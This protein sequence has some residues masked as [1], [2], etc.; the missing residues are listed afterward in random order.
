MAP[1]PLPATALRAIGR[2]PPV[3]PAGVQWSDR[4]FV[5]A[6]QYPVRYRE[7]AQT[8]R[9]LRRPVRI[10]PAIELDVDATLQLRSRR[11]IVSAPVLVP[12]RR[13]I[14]RLLLLVD[15]TG[16]MTPF[17]AFVDEM[18]RAIV[19]AANLQRVVVRYFKNLPGGG[20]D[21]ALL[22]RLRGQLSPALDEILGDIQPIGLGR[23]CARP[24]LV[25][26]ASLDEI[27]AEMGPGTGAAIVS[28][29]GAARGSYQP[30]RLLDTVAFLKTLRA[31][32]HR[33]VWLNPLDRA[34]WDG[35][36]A[37]EIAR[38][39]PMF[40]ITRP[41]LHAAVDV[42]RGRPVRLERPL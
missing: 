15:R 20:A 27:V 36:T 14:A 17:H 28:D 42:L 16:S 13:N 3:T 7:A 30:R 41:D 1:V 35:T 34:D 9:R 6:P 2:L 11:G 4:P 19:V 22:S 8:W 24:D 31:R 25:D 12:R 32:T 18:V 33:V 10:G 29:A 21:P 23:V 26:V 40:S 37:A 5:F 38:H 39:T